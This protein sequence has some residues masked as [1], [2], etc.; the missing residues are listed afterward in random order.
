MKL[1]ITSRGILTLSG[2]PDKTNE[3]LIRSGIEVIKITR[4]V[5]EEGNVDYNFWQSENPVK[6]GYYIYVNTDLESIEDEIDTVLDT[7]SDADYSETSLFTIHNLRNC[8]LDYEKKIVGNAL[9]NCASGSGIICGTSND[10]QM[11]DFLLATVFVVENLVH[12]N[13][14]LDAAEIVEKVHSCNSVCQQTTN[15]TT[16]CNC[17]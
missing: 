17:R 7:D 15:K 9:C 6:D 16:K 1:D 2:T 5:N 8:L 4:P 11:A 14:Y 12:K 10:R 13:H 3:F